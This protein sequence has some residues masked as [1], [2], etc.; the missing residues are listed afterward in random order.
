[1]F[2]R[3]IAIP[4][5]L[6]V[7]AI[8]VGARLLAISPWADPHVDMHAYWATR[9]GFDYLQATPGEVGAFLYSPA[10]AQALAPLTA[11]P[12]PVFA[13]LWTAILI[14]VLY[15]LS[16]R[17]TLLVGIL[18]PVALSIGIGQVDLLIAAVVV[19]GFRYPAAWALPLLTKVTPGVGLVWF[20]VRR[21]WRSLWL[22]SAATLGV[23][24]VSMAIDPA[25]WAGWLDMLRRGHAPLADAGL[26]V[27]LPL[28]VRFPV[29]AGIVAWGARTDRRW[30]VAVGTCLAMPTLWAT[31]FTIL[32][33][34]LPLIALGSG[35]P[36]G[37]WLRRAGEQVGGRLRPATARHTTTARSAD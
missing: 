30:T 26:F 23:V 8:F 14:A 25:G 6:L 2:V 13:A 37:A 16:G 32:V 18:P 27:D 24:A 10:F 17:A 11:L 19:A 12:W 3:R 4:A 33:A 34:A 15:W 36:A 21:D 1:V 31:S 7:G 28:W 9:D 29:A 22:A 5:F 20:F 35:A